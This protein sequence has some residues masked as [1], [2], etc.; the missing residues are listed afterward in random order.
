MIYFQKQSARDSLKP[1]VSYEI[2]HHVFNYYIGSL[3][4]GKITRPISDEASNAL[5]EIWTDE[6]GKFSP[7]F[8]NF[9]FQQKV[10][11]VIDWHD[12]ALYPSIQRVIA[13]VSCKV[14][15]GDELCRN[16]DWFRVTT[17]YAGHIIRAAEG[18]RLWPRILRPIVAMFLESTRTL[19][20][21][22]QATR[23]I[24]MPILEKRRKDK[25]AAANEGISLKP[26][27]DAMQWMEDIANGRPYDPAVMQ[28]ALATAAI[29]TT[30][31][32]LTQAVFDLVGKEGLI[33]ELRGEMVN[34][35]REDGMKKTAMYKLQL[36]DSCLKE[37]QRL[38]PI[39][40]GK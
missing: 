19:Q 22:V 32:F 21:E 17:N 33:S 9:I 10:L 14:F 4:V 29:L 26:N 30:T 18:L 35:L 37:S 8:S 16:E 20:R 7:T 23:D 24:M 31:D 6:Q 11:K 28:L 39:A 1:R 13:R 15:L 2:G 12:I 25:A 36:L 38:K 3:I 34:V 40:L 27:D 5:H